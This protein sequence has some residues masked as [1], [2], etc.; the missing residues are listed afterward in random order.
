MGAPR[1]YRTPRTGPRVGERN[2]KGRRDTIRKGGLDGRSPRAVVG[3]EDGIPTEGRADLTRE[4]R[5]L[6]DGGLV[7]GEQVS[8][9]GVRT[10][11]GSV[12]CKKNV[13]ENTIEHITESDELYQLLMRK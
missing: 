1:R 5:G 10:I 13:S 4:N 8:L 3:G 6:V 2:E 12:R 9:R 11:E 7:G